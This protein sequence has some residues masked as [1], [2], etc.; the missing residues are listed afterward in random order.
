MAQEV[1]N[2]SKKLKFR[3]TLR[4]ILEFSYHLKMRMEKV[5]KKTCLLLICTLT[6]VKKLKIYLQEVWSYLKLICHK[7]YKNYIPSAQHLK[8]STILLVLLLWIDGHNPINNTIS[9]LLLHHHQLYHHQPE[10]HQSKSKKNLNIYSS[11]VSYLC[12]IKMMRTALKM[13]QIKMEHWTKNLNL[14]IKIQS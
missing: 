5:Q 1:H 6:R 7:Y 9:M 10:N 2:I 12:T 13:Y 8:R 4:I 14:R 11:S 3:N